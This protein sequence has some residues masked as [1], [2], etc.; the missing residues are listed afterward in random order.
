M[1]AKR[2][3]VAIDGPAG[4]GKSTIARRIAARM[5]FLY[6]DTG[7]MYRAVALWAERN[8]TSLDDHLN[9]EQLAKAAEIE[10]RSN[11][12]GVVLNGEDITEL[13]RNPEISQAASKASA[14]PSVRRA[15]VEKQRAMGEQTSIVMEGRDI[16]TVVFPDAEVKIFLDAAAE[17]RAQRRLD[18]LQAKGQTELTFEAVLKDINER[19]TRDRSRS[20]APLMQAPD[21]EYVD[22][23]KHSIEEVEDRI[24]ALVRARFSNGK[25]LKK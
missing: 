12:L 25:E 11:P 20:E 19:D 22:S 10:L 3:V 5:G 6:I 2:V 16:G 21:A 24:L 1:S 7:A 15:L 18:E 9:L 14:I 23:T 17:V 13:I 4:A 8:G